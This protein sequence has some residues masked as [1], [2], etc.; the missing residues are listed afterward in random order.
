[1]AVEVMFRVSLGMFFKQNQF[2]FSNKI[3]FVF[4]AKSV[5]FFKQNQFGDVSPVFDLCC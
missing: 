3:S 2:C 4:Q 1:M 5:L